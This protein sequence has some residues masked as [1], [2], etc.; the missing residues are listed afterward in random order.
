M[1][2]KVYVVG[3][4]CNDNGWNFGCHAFTLP[5]HAIQ[6]MRDYVAKFIRH[7]RSEGKEVKGL[8][9]L[10]DTVMED[11]SEKSQTIT[12]NVEGDLYDFRVWAVNLHSERIPAKDVINY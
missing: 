3:C 8:Y 4:E 7:R 6:L 5:E 11:A 1:S 12:F 9:V 10:R 2:K